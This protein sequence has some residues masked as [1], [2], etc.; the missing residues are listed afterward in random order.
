MLHLVLVN[1]FI[2]MIKRLPLHFLKHFHFVFVSEKEGFDE[3]ETSEEENSRRVCP[4]ARRHRQ[5][6]HPA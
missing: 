5:E 2:S 6:P 4:P 3:S 1:P